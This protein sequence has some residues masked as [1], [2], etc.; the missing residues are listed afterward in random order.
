MEDVVE[1]VLGEQPVDSLDIEDRRED[2]LGAVV[3]VGAEA[4]GQ[5]I[6]RDHVVPPGEQLVDHVGADET[7]GP[8]DQ[9]LSRSSMSWRRA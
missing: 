5:V 4:A 2:E 9:D 3:E 6:E 7:G 1:P 8:G